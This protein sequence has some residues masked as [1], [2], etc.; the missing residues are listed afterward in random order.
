MKK[1]NWPSFPNYTDLKVEDLEWLLTGVIES[2]EVLAKSIGAE[3]D[4]IRLIGCEVTVTAGSPTQY[5]ITAG[6]IYYIGEIYL[7]EAFSGSSD[8]QIPVFTISETDDPDDDHKLQDGSDFA[9]RKDRKLSIAIADSGSGDFDYDEIPGIPFSGSWQDA[10]LLNGWTTLSNSPQTLK[11]RKL[12]NGNV[13]L[14]GILIGDSAVT[15]DAVFMNLP[16]GFRPGWAT[17]FVLAYEQASSTIESINITQNG[18]LSSGL[19]A[20]PIKALHIDTIF[21]AHA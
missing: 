12:A 5:D 19:Y 21:Y 17:K 7:V 13:H 18:N 11:Y 3:S 20:Q 8:T 10:V 16:A 15:T 6:A 14:Q 1:L 9:V 4:I 2:L